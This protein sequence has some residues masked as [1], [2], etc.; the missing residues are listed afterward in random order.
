MG[1]WQSP[2]LLGRPFNSEYNDFYFVVNQDGTSAFLSS[3]RPHD[4][5]A[6]E[7]T[8]CNDIFY[9]EW[10]LP[11]KEIVEPDPTPSVHEKIASVLPITLY[12]Q[13]DCPDPKSVSDTTSMDYLALYNT[14][15]A[16]IQEHIH[17]AGQGL[18]G[19]E[20]RKAMYAVAG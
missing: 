19:D 1:A 15:I 16:D 20:Q 18:T 17:K 10:K 4:Y 11:E 6:D 12:F 14:Y 3:N 7:D 13:N 5:M 9:V 8:C 2:T